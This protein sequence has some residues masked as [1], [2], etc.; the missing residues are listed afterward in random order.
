M[1]GGL[2]S[3]CWGMFDASVYHVNNFRVDISILSIVYLMATV[4]GK[5]H[6]TLKAGLGSIGLC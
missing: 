5:M 1:F 6:S 3:V 2:S 4:L